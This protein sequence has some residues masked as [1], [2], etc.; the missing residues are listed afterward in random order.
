MEDCFSQK[1]LLA[2]KE[3]GRREY[4]QLH[5]TSVERAGGGGKKE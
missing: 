5:R 4:Q 1:R 2:V 3:S